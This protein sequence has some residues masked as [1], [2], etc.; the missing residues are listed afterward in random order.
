MLGRD[1]ANTDQRVGLNNS[2]S[3]MILHTEPG[4]HRLV[5]LS[6][7]RDLR[8]PIPGYGEDRINSALTRGGTALAVRTVEN[9]TGLGIN[10]VMI[11]DFRS[12]KRLIDNI[13]G[14][15]HQPPPPLLSPKLRC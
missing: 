9:F 8:V 15:D 7:P 13:G 5:Y 3:I 14:G 10:H 4:R 1:H 6:I 12:F 11:V 2:D